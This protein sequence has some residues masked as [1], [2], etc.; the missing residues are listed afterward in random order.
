MSEEKNPP[1]LKYS[2]LLLRKSE[3]KTQT[4]VSIAVD[5]FESQEEIEK[6][7]SAKVFLMVIKHK[8]IVDGLNEHLPRIDF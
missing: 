2:V 5:C 4:E 8:S 1:E 3:Q 6:M 7:F